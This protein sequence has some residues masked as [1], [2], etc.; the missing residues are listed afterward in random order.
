MAILILTKNGY[1]SRVA[2]DCYE[3]NKKNFIKQG[4]TIKGEAEPI[5]EPPIPTEIPIQTTQVPKEPPKEKT[6]K[7]P[8]VDKSE[9]PEDGYPTDDEMRGFL[10][11]KGVKYTHAM[12][13]KKLKI[14]FDEKK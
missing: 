3:R 14:L 10:K 12:G 11:E 9:A 6:V 5:G 13:R 2:K 8:K 1:D 4:F 7:I